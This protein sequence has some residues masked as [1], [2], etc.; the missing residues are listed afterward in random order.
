MCYFP[1]AEWHEISGKCFP[2]TYWGPGDRSCDLWW[3]VC[4]VASTI[5]NLFCHPP[6]Y[7]FQVFCLLLS[8][9]LYVHVQVFCWVCNK[10]QVVAVSLARLPVV[11]EKWNFSL[12]VQLTGKGSKQ[13]RCWESTEILYLQATMYYFVHYIN[14]LL[15]RRSRLYSS[16]KKKKCSH[17]FMAVNKVSDVSAADW[18]NQTHAKNCHNF[19][20]VEI[21]FFSV[22]E[23]PIED[24]SLYY[25]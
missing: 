7:R 15:T 17:S 12:N 1:L 18:L 8:N 5:T 3:S 19:S 10:G 16:F 6:Y 21:Q 4:F 14:T 2:H 25:L 22:V 23:I 9:S 11:C 13:V 24:S 20:H